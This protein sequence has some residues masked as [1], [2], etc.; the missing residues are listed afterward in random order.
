MAAESPTIQLTFLHVDTGDQFMV[1]LKLDTFRPLVGE[2]RLNRPDLAAAIEDVTLSPPACCSRADSSTTP[3]SSN[4]S[5]SS[6]A[7]YASTAPFGGCLP[8]WRDAV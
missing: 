5:S 3:R 1:T 2:V 8:D 7:S 4:S 6:L